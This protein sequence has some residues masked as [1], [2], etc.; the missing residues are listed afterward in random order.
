MK[1][2]RLHFSRKASAAVL[3]CAALMSVLLFAIVSP[4]AAQPSAIELFWTALASGRSS[5]GAAGYSLDSAIGQPVA[6]LSAG[7][8][9]PYQLCAGYL[10]AAGGGQRL[11]LPLVRK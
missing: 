1:S 5:S 3:I 2:S 9:G 8:S 7:G 11:L 10:C 6:S 4:A